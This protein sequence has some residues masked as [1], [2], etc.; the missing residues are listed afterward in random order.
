[1]R[2]QVAATFSFFNNVIGLM[3]GATY[4]AL[5]TDYFFRDSTRLHHSLVVVAARCCP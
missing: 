1:M 3:F 2:G 4:V 5:L